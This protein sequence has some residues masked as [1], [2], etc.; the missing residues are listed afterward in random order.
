MLTADMRWCRMLQHRARAQQQQQQQR[1]DATA[2]KRRRA[3]AD[4]AT[5]PAAGA[6]EPVSKAMRPTADA[7]EGAEHAEDVG[8]GAPPAAPVDTAAAGAQAAVAAS[9]EQAG[10]VAPDIANATASCPA[11][12]ASEALGSTQAAMLHGA[13]GMDLTG[14]RIAS[15]DAEHAG[16]QPAPPASAQARLAAQYELAQGEGGQ[17]RLGHP[18][19]DRLADGAAVP[20]S[21]DTNAAAAVALGEV[22]APHLRSED[23]ATS[24]A[25]ALDRTAGAAA[26]NTASTAARPAQQQR[27]AADAATGADADKLAGTAPADA[28]AAAAQ[29]VGGDCSAAEGQASNAAALLH[30][31]APAALQAGQQC[32]GAVASGGDGHPGA[33][34]A[35][36]HS[37]DRNLDMQAS[38]LEHGNARGHGAAS[39]QHADAHVA[40]VAV[41]A[42]AQP[43]LQTVAEPAVNKNDSSD[44]MTAGPAAPRQPE[45]GES[46]R[47]AQQAWAVK[48][49]RHSPAGQS[50]AGMAAASL[51]HAPQDQPERGSG[52]LTADAPMPAPGGASSTP[53][54]P[55]VAAAEPEGT[56][57]AGQPAA[58]AGPSHDEASAD[59]AQRGGASTGGTATLRAH[60]AAGTLLE[61]HVPRRSRSE[62]KTR[63]R[64]RGLSGG[65]AQGSADAAAPSLAARRARRQTRKAAALADAASDADSFDERDGAARSVADFDS[66]SQEERPSSPGATAAQRRRRPANASRSKGQQARAAARALQRSPSV[67]AADEPP[68]S[69]AATRAPRAARARRRSGAGPGNLADVSPVATVSTRRHSSQSLHARKASPAAGSLSARSQ[70]E[71]GLPPAAAATAEHSAAQLLHN[72]SGSL[73]ARDSLMPALPLVNNFSA[74]S[75]DVPPGQS[76]ELPLQVAPFSELPGHHDRRASTYE[77]AAGLRSASHSQLPEASAQ[78]SGAAERGV[79]GALGSGSWLPSAHAQQAAPEHQTAFQLLSQGSHMPAEQQSGA[80]AAPFSSLAA[81][82]QPHACAQPAPPAVPQAPMQAHAQPFLGA[83]APSSGY[84]DVAAQLHSLAA[85]QPMTSWPNPQGLMRLGSDFASGHSSGTGNAHA[86]AFVSWYGQQPALQQQAAAMQA[87][88]ESMWPQAL[89]HAQQNAPQQA[90]HSYPGSMML[91]SGGLHDG[92]ALFPAGQPTFEAS[93]WHQQ[94]H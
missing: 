86:S 62:R 33:L 55:R 29:P 2:T 93:M 63:P 80:D 42:P 15:A 81:L 41:D 64:L 24:R 52:A 45:G 46:A 87:Y 3:S 12:P 5:D 34:R 13:P 70:P 25:P 4:A 23:P 22:A 94:H 19:A 30:T 47:P 1:Q 27:A 69:L 82:M 60:A 26:G 11:E 89:Q 90:M 61:A 76:S 36:K 88:P 71:E 9:D 57:P 37:T 44:G 51:P 54:A 65:A 75:Q 10:A 66:A 59:A 8:A 28:D 78:H 31:A 35:G 72:A 58:V 18:T 85:Q 32:T 43:P 79:L 21:A 48:S 20:Q 53:S 16:A 91:S 39:A 40:E 68:D 14:P 56:R 6:G 77:P 7:A 84:N 17:Q 73:T 38:L 67:Q 74:L 49:G 50:V 83:S 92:Q